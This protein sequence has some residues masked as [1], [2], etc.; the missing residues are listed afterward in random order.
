MVVFAII[1]VSIVVLTGWAGQVSL[2]QMSFVAFG[3]AIGALR[4]PDLAP[5]PQPRRCSWPGSSARS[6]PCRRAARA[7]AAGPVPGR[8]HPRLRPGHVQLPAEP[9]PTSAGSRRAGVDR[10]QLFGDIDLELAGRILLPVPRRAWCL[11]CSRCGHPPQPHRS[12][13][14]RPA[15]ERARRAVFGINVIAGQ[16]HRL[17]PVGLPRRLRRV[18]ARA[19]HRRRSAADLYGPGE[20]FAVFTTAVVGGLGSLLGAVLGALYLPRR[21]VVPARAPVA[22]CRRP[23]ACCSCCW[24]SRRAR[25]A[26]ST[27]CGTTGCAG[28]PARTGIVVPSLLA[29]VA[30]P[31]D[32]PD[33]ERHRSTPRTAI[34]WPRSRPTDRAARAAE[35]SARRRGRPGVDGAAAELVA[36]RRHRCRRRRWSRDPDPPLRPTPGPGTSAPRQASP[37]PASGSATS[38]ATGRSTP[39]DPVRPQHGRRARPHGVRPAAARTSA[40]ASASPTPASC[41]WSRWRS[42]VR[43]AA[44]GAD[45]PHGRPPQPR[46]PRCSSA[47]PSGR[48][49]RSAPAWPSRS[50]MLVDR[51]VR[52]RHRPG[53]RSTRPTTRCSPTT[54]RSTTGPRVFSFHRAANAVGAF[55]ARSSAGL[56]ACGVR[57]AGA[58]H[59]LRHPDVRAGRRSA[60]GCA[61]RS[62]APGAPGDGRRPTRSPPRSRRRRSPRAGGWCG[63]SRA[64]GAS[65]IALP[66]LAASLIGFVVAG[67]RSCTSRSSASTRCQ[68]AGSR[69]AVEPVQLVG[70]VIGARIGTKLHGPRP[71][72]GPPVHRRRSPFVTAALLGACSRSRRHVW[73][74]DRSP[75]SAISASP[76]H[77]RARRA[78]LAL[79]GHPAPGPVDRASRWARSG[80]IPG[81]AHAAARR[82]ASATP[83]HPLGH[84]ADGAGVPRSAG[85][86]SPRPA[87]SS[88][89]TS[90]RCGRRPPPAPRCSTSGARAG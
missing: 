80:C 67:R 34:N 1:A 84:V 79:A 81:P 21:H 20:S 19:R 59:R 44:A 2:G 32:D 12:G 28:W 58:V 14:A 3:A 48:A 87:T 57:L 71:R 75:T 83:G 53:R 9:R 18:P 45:R 16:A 69:A 61:S 35:R 89:A 26:S 40:T 68:R 29:D 50:W 78:R 11:A 73:V 55:S 31:G 15:R 36:E 41:R 72:P 7:A 33:P 85:S 65:S 63:R 24:S 64:C 90:S 74:G 46:P 27:A 54:T 88:T 60:S 4:H 42:L 66:F 52:L 86:S 56:L 37:I 6:W 30:Q 76:R 17:R 51:P 47:P 39:D 22:A 49:S 43:P 82:L 10:P 70:L 77:R 62:G 23:S 5:R 25:A 13:A 38:P 8:H